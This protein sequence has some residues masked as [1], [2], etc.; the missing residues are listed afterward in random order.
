MNGNR[1]YVAM[2]G[3]APTGCSDCG[4]PMRYATDY[5]MVD[6]A[7][8]CTAL[9]VAPSAYERSK[10]VE[11]TLL[12]VV[13]LEKRLGRYLTREDFIDAPVNEGLFG[14]SRD[15]F[16]RREEPACVS[17]SLSSGGPS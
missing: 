13:C 10:R 1:I 16:P 4:K 14:F 2:D 8:W 9:G 11:E 7:L 3:H 12:H 6:N 15:A 17:I 5:Y